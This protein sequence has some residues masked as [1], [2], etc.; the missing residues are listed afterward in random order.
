MYDIE[1]LIVQ[2]CYTPLA[3]E[4]KRTV[5]SLPALFLLSHVRSI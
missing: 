1:S 4:K 2:L 3:A 5:R